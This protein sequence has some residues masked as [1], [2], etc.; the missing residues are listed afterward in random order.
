MNRWY[1]FGNCAGQPQLNRYFFSEKKKD[2]KVAK[3]VC[4][5][6]PVKADCFLEGLGFDGTWAGLTVDQ[7]EM[8]YSL[9]G[10][11]KG[12]ELRDRCYTWFQARKQVT[13]IS[14]QDN[15]GT[16]IVVLIPVLP[17]L[18]PLRPLLPRLSPQSL[19]PLA[20]SS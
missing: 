7:R 15:I 3:A 8:L 10:S 18:P 13:H 12:S 19:A 1:W 20:V 4:R 9:W 16:T 11:P 6:C 14:N 5:G 2:V 17:K